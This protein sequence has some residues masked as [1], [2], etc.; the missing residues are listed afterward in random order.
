M[1]GKV[2]QDWVTISSMVGATPIV[3]GEPFW[4][5]VSGYRDAIAWFD[6]REVNVGGA[7]SLQIFFETAPSCD[8]VLF[9]TV[10]GPVNFA[11]GTI[12]VTQMLGTVAAVPLAK[13]LRWKVAPTAS[14]TWDTTFRVLVAL[15]RPGYRTP[16]YAAGG[17]LGPIKISPTAPDGVQNGFGQKGEM[18]QA[19]SP[20]SL[21][22]FLKKK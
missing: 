12:T 22:N 15:N 8:E 6:V 1:D 20:I 10:G 18:G 21:N 16:L 2:L 17:P 11:A 5:D 14:F 19:Q 7:G 4:L 9:T 3:Q 13:Y